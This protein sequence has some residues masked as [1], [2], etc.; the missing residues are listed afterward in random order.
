MAHQQVIGMFET[1]TDPITGE[2]FEVVSGRGC[3]TNVKS[4]TG[5]TFEAPPYYRR[6]A[7]GTRLARMREAQEFMGSMT[8]L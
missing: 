4:S 6:P 2:S 1:P 3:Y 5:T 7:K 8:R